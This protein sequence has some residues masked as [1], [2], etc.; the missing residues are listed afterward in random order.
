MK[1]KSAGRR[2]S[3]SLIVGLLL[4]PTAAVAA[5]FVVDPGIPANASSSDLALPEMTI[6]STDSTAI[7]QTVIVEP[8]SADSGDLEAACGA[9]GLW[10]AGLEVE[11]SISDVQ[12]AALDALREVCA[13]AGLALPDP[14][15]PP[16]IVK[17]VVKES[18]PATDSVSSDTKTDYQDDEREHEQEDDE[19][20]D[21]EHEQEHEQEH[22]EGH[23]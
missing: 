3:M 8:V 11:D 18:P 10:L 16:P 19:E 9:D 6:P 20:H 14:P 13:K 2:L 5:Y 7:G 4:V 15:A 12:Q 17:T 23:D 22:E 21:E 1:E